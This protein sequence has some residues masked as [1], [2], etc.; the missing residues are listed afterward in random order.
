MPSSEMIKRTGSTGA[1]QAQDEDLHGHDTAKLSAV[2][3]G[4]ACE[5]VGP[6]TGGILCGVC[7]LVCIVVES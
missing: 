3:V 6:R 1:S 4:V 2:D 5:D 7:H